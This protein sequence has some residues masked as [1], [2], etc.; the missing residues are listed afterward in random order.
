MQCSGLGVRYRF[1]DGMAAR[2]RQ[3]GKTAESVFGSS[4]AATSGNDD[5]RTILPEARAPSQ[6]GEL[7]LHHQPSPTGLDPWA[8]HLI[9]YCEYH[10]HC[11][12]SGLLMH[13]L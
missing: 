5:Q 4:K 2:G 13:N 10:R 7:V 12:H 6:A 3:A 8:V 11:V 1:N 9:R